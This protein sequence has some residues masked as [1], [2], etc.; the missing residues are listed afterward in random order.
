MPGSVESFVTTKASCWPVMPAKCV[1][2]IHYRK[3]VHGLLKGLEMATSLHFLHGGQPLSWDPMLTW[4]H[5]STRLKTIS[6]WSAQFCRHT[7]N[8]VAEALSKLSP[9]M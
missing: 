3:K 7:A 8:V 4:K 2:Q 1:P 9:P 6:Q 5:I